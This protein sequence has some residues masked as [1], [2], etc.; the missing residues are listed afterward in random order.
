MLAQFE[1]QSLLVPLLA[2]L[3]CRAIAT[4]VE[5]RLSG[6]APAL[7]VMLGAISAAIFSLSP[8]KIAPTG[9]YWLAAD[10]ASVAAM[11]AAGLAAGLSMNLAV[12]EQH[13]GL[14]W[15][16]LMAGL[17][18][19]AAGLALAL[20]FGLINSTYTYDMIR[21]AAILAAALWLSHQS[22]LGLLAAALALALASTA[23]MGA[24]SAA[25]AT[26]ILVATLAVAAGFGK[27]NPGAAS[28][29]G[30]ALP[31]IALGL[32]WALR[33]TGLPWPAA[34]LAAGFSM[35]LVRRTIDDSRNASRKASGLWKQASA[36]T[37]Y[38]LAFIAG[39]GISLKQASANA[40]AIVIIAASVLLAAFLQ[41]L[42]AGKRTSFLPNQALAFA[43]LL[44]ARKAGL[45]GDALMAG[46][47]MAYLIA[48]P[49]TRRFAGASTRG[50]TSASI[51]ALVG[52]S[53]KGATYGILSF[54]SAIG[55]RGDPIRA[56]CVASANPNSG[57][58]TTEAEEALVRCVA[59]G[60][61]ADI[62]VLPSVIVS[63][64]VPDGLARAAL[65]R[66]ADAV[67][68]GLGEG[69]P[70]VEGEI[71]SALAGLLVAF[72]GAV[73]AIQRAE[74][75]KSSRRL[76]AMAVAGVETSPGFGAALEASARA[77]GRPVGAMEAFMVG[78]PASALVEASSGMLDTRSV[79]SVQTW[80]DV[81][82]ALTG[83]VTAGTSFVVFS[84][85]PGEPAWN[86]GHERLPV[87]LDTAFSDSSIVLWFLPK[88][89]S[90]YP[91]D[92]V[93]SETENST[94]AMGQERS[95]SA[96]NMQR[97]A[98]PPIIASAFDSGRILTDMGEEALV[99]AIRRLTD[100]I[101]P[102]D[103]VASGRLTTLFS[104]IA[105]KTPIELSEGVLL[106][107][108]H[109]KGVNLPTLAIG[110][111]ASG[112][113]LVALSSPVRILIAI[114]SPQQSGPEMHLEA[115]TQIATAF[116]S[117]GLAD[118]LLS[119]ARQ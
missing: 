43:A 45:A 46:V 58:G 87:V 77:L 101:I 79:T 86:P 22:G 92:D 116:R 95:D 21:V 52:V 16:R 75:F 55:A 63:A 97:N 51:K 81:P 42:I 108:A 114:V 74:T 72:P 91:G 85:R 67:L 57:P 111:R 27:N 113:P 83:R 15:R 10:A 25:L 62:R 105:R 11:L 60:T 9:L 50:Q 14:G 84:S 38:A 41:S 39:Y 40:L 89:T 19:I 69:T 6:S 48:L 80:R 4:L 32:A 2:F 82:S 44:V 54:A 33:A 88:L 96:L 106:L 5:K 13:A 17:V 102:E 61:A 34:G 118:H 109:A 76:I 20:G 104:S 23:S 28:F 119:P 107:H 53:T 64:S 117:Q 103:R 94:V 90:R 99:D 12:S 68:V 47:A 66:H 8:T 29:I 49:L 65:E 98:W 70:I 35:A 93:E 112:W 59:T 37:H 26:V 56:A 73:V 100:A 71:N 30:P 24:A 36:E 110:A 78:A 1:Y 3:A 7:L 115:L 18:P 31:A